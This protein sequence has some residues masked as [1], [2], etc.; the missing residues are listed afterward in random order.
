MLI[1]TSAICLL[2]TVLFGLVPAVHG[3]RVDV[4][5]LLKSE[6]PSVAGDA[7]RGVRMRRFFLITQF[8]SSMALVV[9]AGTFVRT[10]VT[11]HLGEQSAAM[12]YLVV[13]GVEAPSLQ[14]RPAR[15][16]L[17]FRAR[18]R[19]SACPMSARSRSPSPA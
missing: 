5:P 1:Y 10:V 8:A 17:A 12:D 13:A 19:C 18:R 6:M 9:V 3:T 4:A 16:L 15:R 11:A 7:R 14:G 2:A